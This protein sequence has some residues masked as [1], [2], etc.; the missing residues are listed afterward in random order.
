MLEPIGTDL[1]SQTVCLLQSFKQLSDPNSLTSC[2]DITEMSVS[3]N[4]QGTHGVSTR[5]STWS[6]S[7]EDID[8]LMADAANVASCSAAK[9]LYGSNP[10]TMVWALR[11][12]FVTNKTLKH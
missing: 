7:L 1:N 12:G 5:T 8:L 3:A 2:R 6:L 9:V 4:K 10:P 11:Q